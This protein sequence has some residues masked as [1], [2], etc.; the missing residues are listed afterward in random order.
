M[1][2]AASR[3]SLVALL[4][5]GGPIGGA[6]LLTPSVANAQQAVFADTV[7]ELLPPGEVVGDGV[8]PVTLHFLALNADGSALAGATLKATISAGKVGAVEA[9]GNG[10]YKVTWTPPKVDAARGYDLFV[11]GKTAD[12]KIVDGKW[13]L[14][15]VPSLAQMVTISA[16]PAS[17]VLGQD[18]SA[19]LN[20]ALAGGPSQPLEGVELDVRAS[21]GTVTNVTHLGGGKFTALYTP[22][23]QPFPQLAVI[24]VAD[25]RD[26]T[27]T[28][29]AISLALSGKASF[30]LDTLTEGQQ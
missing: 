4:A 19:S 2:V 17:L 10:L 29:G 7:F 13:S 27:R 5:I 6:L 8:T 3:V 1:G 30:Q 12:K 22:P 25:R 15:T 23:A 26:P 20:I 24:T 16:N 18:S 28:Y 11:K 14:N 21:A 9:A